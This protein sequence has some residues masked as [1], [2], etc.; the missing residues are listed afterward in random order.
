MSS[1]RFHL[2][3]D[4]QAHAL[5]SALRQHGI[6]VV[7]TNEAGLSGIDDETQL[8]QASEHGRVIISNNIRDFV[9]L[10]ARWLTEG[11]NP[12]HAGIVIF[13]QQEFSI[14]ETVRRLTRLSRSLSPEEM[15]NRLEWL[16]SWRAT[17][18]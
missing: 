6:D 7:T 15:K 16:S 2:D 14:G 3:E 10:H 12:A 17:P 9:A 1:L 18:A 5:A 11:N 8:R 4:C 13:A